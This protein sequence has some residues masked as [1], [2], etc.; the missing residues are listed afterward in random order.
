MIDGRLP[1]GVPKRHARVPFRQRHAY[2]AHM[3]LKWLEDLL[4]L[5]DAGSLVRAAER[6]HVTHPA[7]GRRIRALEAWAGAPL[8]DRAA[9]ALRFTPQGEALLEGARGR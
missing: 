1:R 8:I 3:Q 9:P 5:A 4:A 6:R 7:F 2:D